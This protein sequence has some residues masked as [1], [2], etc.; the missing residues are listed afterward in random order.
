MNKTETKLTTKRL[1][2]IPISAKYRQDIFNEFTKNITTYMSPQPTGKMKDIDDFIIESL[3][4]MKKGT[5]L[6]LVALDK[7]TKEF[8]GC[9][10][11]HHINKKAS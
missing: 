3:D 11:L 9:V 6:Q 10:G 4:E 5:N 2:L 8:L 7:K 1:S